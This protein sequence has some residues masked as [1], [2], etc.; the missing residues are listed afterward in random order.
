MNLNADVNPAANVRISL[1]MN[2]GVITANGNGNLRMGYKSGDLSLIGDYMISEGEFVFTI[3][4]LIKM[5][6][7]LRGGTITWSGDITDADIDVVGSYRTNALIS[8]LGI[9]TDS[10]SV[11]E[12]VMWIASSVLKINL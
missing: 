6:F 10:T 2:I 1:P 7:V 12:K 8:S 3:Q 4:N 5:D 9:E 11:G